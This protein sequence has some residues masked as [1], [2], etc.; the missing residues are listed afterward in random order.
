[1]KKSKGSGRFGRGVGKR[2]RLVL[3]KRRKLG[4]RAEGSE[5]GRDLGNDQKLQMQ[6]LNEVYGCDRGERR[7]STMI[8]FK[9]AGEEQKR[10]SE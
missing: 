1:V 2:R 9:D 10:R 7:L 8:G 6:G 5:A 3:P 4:S